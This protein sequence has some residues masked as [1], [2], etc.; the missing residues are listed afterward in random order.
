MV[1]EQSGG[2]WFYLGSVAG[3]ARCGIHPRNVSC[4]PS[5]SPINSSAYLGEESLGMESLTRSLSD[6][7]MATMGESPLPEKDD[8]RGFAGFTP[9]A[10]EARGLWKWGKDRIRSIFQRCRGWTGM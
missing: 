7:N 10:L 5:T 1:E 6:S 4:L 2:Q 3:D 9:Y 8:A